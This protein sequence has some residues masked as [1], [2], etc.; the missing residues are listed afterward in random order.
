VP[1]LTFVGVG[2][3][4]LC[5]ASAEVVRFA[6][7]VK[8]LFYLGN[9]AAFCAAL[10]R[11]DA[12]SLNSLYRHGEFDSASYARIVDHL[13]KA[14]HTGDCALLLEGHPHVGVTLRTL[15]HK[16]ASAEVVIAALPGISSLDT[17]LI[18]CQF[19]LLD[20]G[21]QVIDVNRLLL[22]KYALEPRLNSVIYHISSVA[23]QR[24]FY[25]DPELTTKIELLQAYLLKFYPQDHFVCLFSSRTSPNRAG[26]VIWRRLSSLAAAVARLDY[27]TSLFIPAVA[28]FSHD[29][30]FL[31][32]VLGGPP[33]TTL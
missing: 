15:A 8:Q 20:P 23:E 16:L 13:L 1:T 5:H 31:R 22:F 33:V 9:V 27:A 2:I 25:S 28:A 24:T 6:R 11:T 21:T 4:S 12:V 19:D 17:A 18:D 29:Q 14:A 7:N 26:W 3:D 10:P 32:Q 30:N